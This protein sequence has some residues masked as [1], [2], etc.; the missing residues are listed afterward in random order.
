[1]ISY[2][3]VAICRLVTAATLCLALVCC[4]CGCNKD[5]DPTDPNYHG[6]SAQAHG[7]TG[8]AE[9]GQQKSGSPEP[10]PNPGSSVQFGTRMRGGGQ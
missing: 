3:P 8:G 2:R 1:M 4:L 5:K 6:A 7:T 10:T 9:K